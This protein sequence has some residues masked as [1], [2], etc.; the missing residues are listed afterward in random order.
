MRKITI[1][2]I[3]AGTVLAAGLATAT[4]AFAGSQPVQA[5]A[6]IPT[7]L[8]L[9]GVPATVDFGTVTPGSAGVQVPVPIDLSTNNATGASVTVMPVNP[10]TLWVEKDGTTPVPNTGTQ[11]LGMRSGSLGGTVVFVDATTGVVWESSNTNGDNSYANDYWIAAF[12][13]TVTI[14]GNVSASLTVSATVN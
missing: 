8:S 9:T 10:G 7:I 2:G 6:T 3:I 4:P 13:A 14:G 11:S 5:T 1:T 12:P